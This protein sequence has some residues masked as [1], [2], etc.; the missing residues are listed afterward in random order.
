MHY[1][2]KLCPSE[3]KKLLKSA[4][5]HDPGETS[6]DISYATNGGKAV[7]SSKKLNLTVAPTG[8]LVKSLSLTFD[9]YLEQIIQADPNADY[10]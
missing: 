4:G 2:Q 3:I 10:R 5:M 1:N 6:K 8:D 9:N 7:C